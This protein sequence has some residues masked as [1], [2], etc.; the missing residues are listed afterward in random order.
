VTAEIA[1]LN[2]SAIALATDSAVTIGTPSGPKIYESVNK[3][4]VLIKGRPVGV[5]IYDHADLLGVPW[6]TIIKVYRMR[7]RTTSFEHLNQYVDD[8]LQFV[9]STPGLLPPDLHSRY[10]EDACDRR[11]LAV[12]SKVNAAVERALEHHPKLLKK[13][14]RAIIDDTIEAE[15]L[16]WSLQENGQWADRIDQRRLH[17]AIA[18][19]VPKLITGRFKQLPLLNRQEHELYEL[20]ANSFARVPY[21][22]ETPLDP[23]SGVVIAGFG[24]N[25]YFPQLVA[26]D[27]FGF[28]D[29][30][31]RVSENDRI[32]ITVENAAVIAP[33]AQRDMVNA[34][35]AGI[36]PSI[37]RGLR[38]YWSGLE[39]RLPAGIL[40]LLARQM[41]DLDEATRSSLLGP[42]SSLVVL[43]VRELEDHLRALTEDQYKPILD[44]VEFLPKDE[45][46]AM[47]ESL[48]NLTSLKRRISLDAPQ[49]VGGP[50]DVAVI[51]RGDGFV[52][53]K[54]KHY[55]NQELN[56]TWATL[57]SDE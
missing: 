31:L 43:A 17:K 45:L 12:L 44:S 2:K 15:R 57:P 33:F 52:W 8:F 26:L 38:G 22:E 13:E 25:D 34:F 28:I 23:R 9:A 53:I 4:F 55:F 36:N 18:S 37:E 49:T 46:A 47:A 42:L 54:R 19:I 50:I 30:Q 14:L 16:M 7:R 39:K 40:D 11:L 32:T 5:M 35:V 48:V 24:Q 1:I 21:G 51:S 27:I 56:P 6:E 10:L 41:K 20:V 29:G 3:L